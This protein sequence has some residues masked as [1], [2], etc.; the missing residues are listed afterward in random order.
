MRAAL[1]AL[2][3]VM[4]VTAC[5]DITGLGDYGTYDLRSVNGRGLPFVVENTSN[6]R[7][8]LVRSTLTL[9][10]GGEYS[11]TFTWRETEFGSTRT[12]TERFTGYYERE[13][14]DLW[15]YDDFNGDETYGYFDGRSLWVQA[16]GVE[17]E[18]R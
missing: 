8:E 18:Y 12:E 15:L 14:D 3:L 16:G 10:R 17:Y 6:Y 11:T 9:E 7:L 4:S 13:G 2:A 5:S 1:A